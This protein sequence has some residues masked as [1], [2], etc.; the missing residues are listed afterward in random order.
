MDCDAECLSNWNRHNHPTNR[1]RSG[2]NDFVAYLFGVDR[3]IRQG[4]VV[5]VTV[6]N[7]SDSTV[8]FHCAVLDCQPE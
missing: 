8:W 2:S 1:C 6:D 3:L 7:S 4:T 5:E